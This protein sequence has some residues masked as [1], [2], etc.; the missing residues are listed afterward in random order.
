M[1]SVPLEKWQQT[2]GPHTLPEGPAPELQSLQV[3]IIACPYYL[4]A[5][6]NTLS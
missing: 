2:K 6:A 3:E 1:C 5:K 4:P